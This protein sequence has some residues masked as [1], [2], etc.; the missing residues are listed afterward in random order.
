MAVMFMALAAAFLTFQN[1]P[2]P[3]G[4]LKV[5]RP[6][7]KNADD[8]GGFWPTPRMVELGIARWVDEVSERYNLEE[9]QIERSREV[10]TKRWMAFLERNRADFKPLLTDFIEMR[11][12]LKPPTAEQVI[13]WSGRAEKAM[14]LFEAEIKAGEKD[15]EQI[16]RPDQLSILKNDMLAVTSGMMLARGKIGQWKQGEF[17]EF[18]F[19]DP[20]ESVR[21]ERRAQREAEARSAQA[22]AEAKAKAESAKPGDG[23]IHEELDSWSKWVED[24]VLEYEFDTPQRE[25]AYSLLKEKRQSAANYFN[26]H[27]SEI[28]ALE[29]RIAAGTETQEELQKLQEEIKRLYGPIDATF[30]DLKSRVENLAT[31]G[32]RAKVAKKLDAQKPDAAKP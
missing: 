1:S 21:R 14:D 8:E 18:E 20:P 9:P 28:E 25:A 5:E 6:A 19:W 16:L 2:S 17:Q 11:M 24:F 27:Q 3:E 13:D 30:A 15:M 7:A 4:T 12:Q 31:A 32:Q 26:E 23:L 22:E 10:A 29:A